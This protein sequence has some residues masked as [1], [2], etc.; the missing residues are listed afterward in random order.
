V[1]G[2][3]LIYSDGTVIKMGNLRGTTTTYPGPVILMMGEHIVGVKERKGESCGDKIV[4]LSFYAK[5]ING[6]NRHFEVTMHER[7]YCQ[8]WRIISPPSS[9]SVITDND[10]GCAHFIVV[11]SQKMSRWAHNASDAEAVSKSS[12]NK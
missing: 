5:D 7:Q 2:L 8:E 10:H 1:S 12:Q 11:P 6:F 9:C 3:V 4:G